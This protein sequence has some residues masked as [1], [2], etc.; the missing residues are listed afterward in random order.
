MVTQEEQNW[1]RLTDTDIA[2]G[3]EI[4]SKIV[5]YLHNVHSEFLEK[6]K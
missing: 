6:G 2:S 1:I 3:V 5:Q 4:E